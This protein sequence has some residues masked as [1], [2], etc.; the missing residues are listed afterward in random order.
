M[1]DPREIMKARIQDT[2]SLDFEFRKFWVRNLA[3]TMCDFP[4]SQRNFRDDDD[5]DA[6]DNNN[7]NNNNK[8]CK[9]CQENIQQINYELQLYL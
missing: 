8:I 1:C 9:P 2:E 6:D 4:Q 7:N 5:D 3:G